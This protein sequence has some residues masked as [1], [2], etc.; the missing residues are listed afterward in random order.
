MNTPR[1]WEYVEAV[2]SSYLDSEVFKAAMDLD[3]PLNMIE[4]LYQGEYSSDSEFAQEFAEDTGL[5]DANINWP[6]TCI[7]WEYAA[8]ELMFD[9]AESDN[10]YFRTTY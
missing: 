5:L 4:E 8:R 10:H 6:F 7:D 9:Y 1:I 3:I 2:G